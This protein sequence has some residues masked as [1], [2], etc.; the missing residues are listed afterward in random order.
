MV[1]PCYS[2]QL[3]LLAVANKQGMHR[4]QLR[5]DNCRTLYYLEVG[6]QLGGFVVFA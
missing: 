3:P 2:V 4:G 5:Q 1:A 6:K